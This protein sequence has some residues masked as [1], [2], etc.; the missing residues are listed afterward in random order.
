MA[1]SIPNPDQGRLAYW[2]IMTGL[3]KH[4]GE[5]TSRIVVDIAGV[6]HRKT[7]ENYL[8]FLLAENVVRVVSAGQRGATATHRYK[9][10]NLGDAPPLRRGDSTLGQRQQALWT[11]IRSLGQFRSSE[12]ADAASTDT[13]VIARETASGYVQDLLRTGYLAVAGHA[14]ERRQTQIYRLIRNSG[15]RAPIVMRPEKACF[16]LNLMRVVNLNEPALIGRAA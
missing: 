14:P 12:L 16:D 1:S 11:A 9:I 10:V 3:Q 15:P 2:R 5:F 8:A 7:I 13:L 6:G 4:Y